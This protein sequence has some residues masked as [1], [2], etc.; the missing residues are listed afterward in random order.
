MNNGNLLLILIIALISTSVLG[1]SQN[2]ISA[3]IVSLSSDEAI[4]LDGFTVEIDGNP[5]GYTYGGATQIDL[6][7]LSRGYHRV[8]A[9]KDEGEH[10]FEGIKDINIPCI[11]ESSRGQQKITV[12]VKLS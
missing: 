6:S 5:M 11:N 9:Y 12:K 8:K 7:E 4:S 3:L 2:C 1:S 10:Y